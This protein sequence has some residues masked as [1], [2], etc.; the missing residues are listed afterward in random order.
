MNIELRQNIPYCKNFYWY[1]FLTLPRWDIAAVPKS[2]EVYFNL[3]KTATLLQ[4]IRDLI[5]EPITVTSGYRPW[6][7]NEL[8]GGARR[9]RHIF[10]RA[11]DF[12]VKDMDCD[13][14]RKLLEPYVIGWRFRMEDK[15]GSDWVHI[16]LDYRPG[17]N[18]FFK[19]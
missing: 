6:K 3:I 19:P 17:G 11:V 7:Y 15:P 4:R 13:D 1:E 9:S 18:N 16:D 12:R 8:I 10:G 14:L 2:E 5:G